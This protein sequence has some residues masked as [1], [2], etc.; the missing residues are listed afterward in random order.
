L[1]TTSTSVETETRRAPTSRRSEAW[2]MHAD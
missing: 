1:P 2:V